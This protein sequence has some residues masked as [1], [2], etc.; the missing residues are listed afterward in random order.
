MKK[1]LKRA[2]AL[3]LLTIA[4]PAYALAG[5]QGSY[6]REGSAQTS[7]AKM[8]LKSLQTAGREPIVYVQITGA[9]GSEDS[10][11]RQYSYYTA[12]YQ[13]NEKPDKY[14]GSIFGVGEML[15][16]LSPDQNNAHLQVTGDIPSY[17][18]ANY[19]YNMKDVEFEE[20]AAVDL[21]QNAPAVITSLRGEYEIDVEDKDE[22]YLIKATKNNVRIAVFD[23][24]KNFNYIKRTDVDPDFSVYTP[25]DNDPAPIT[26]V[27][28][29]PKDCEA[30]LM[31]FLRLDTM[32]SNLFNEGYELRQTD[33]DSSAG[34]WQNYFVLG[35]EKPIDGFVIYEKFSVGE[36]KAI[37]RLTD[38]GYKKI[39]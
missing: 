34:L 3:S 33:F 2:L 36:D 21:I 19:E 30:Y 5:V 9:I 18:S 32:Y 22:A 4:I 14:H 37:H 17:F 10:T 39:N 20:F 16:T 38:E 26:N 6:S 31:D 24:A 11:P 27:S 12:C 29:M 15:L 23:V 1:T 25:D 7:Y 28:F 13:D 35:K 8:Q